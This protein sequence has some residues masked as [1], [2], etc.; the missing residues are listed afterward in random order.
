MSLNGDS[1]TGVFEKYSYKTKGYEGLCLSSDDDR[2][3]PLILRT[4]VDRS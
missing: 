2:H 4:A 3:K 1:E